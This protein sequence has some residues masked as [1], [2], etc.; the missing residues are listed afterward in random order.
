[1]LLLLTVRLADS[2]LPHE[3]RLEVYY[4]ESWGTVCD[5]NFDD[6][7]AAVACNSLGYGT[8]LVHSSVS[9]E[10]TLKW[11]SKGRIPLF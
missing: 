3:G 4:N 6:V 9:R 1:V 10:T 5:D 2:V 7:D 11:L 8:G